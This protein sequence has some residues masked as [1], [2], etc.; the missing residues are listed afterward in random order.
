MEVDP[1]SYMRDIFGYQTVIEFFAAAG[2]ALALATY[3]IV[4]DFKMLTEVQFYLIL[5]KS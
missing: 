5:K 2:I 4:P 1:V 3:W